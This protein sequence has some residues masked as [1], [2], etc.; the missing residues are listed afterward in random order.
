M[1][2]TKE[3]INI[4]NILEEVLRNPPSASEDI[5]S[6]K[7]K[8]LIFLKDYFEEYYKNNYSSKPKIY[9][10]IK[11]DT[12]TLNIPSL[13]NHW[14][15]IKVGNGKDEKGN[16]RIILEPFPVGTSWKTISVDLYIPYNVK[17]DIRNCIHRHA[18][19]NFYDKIMKIVKRID[20]NIKE[21]IR[22]VE[23]QPFNNYYMIGGSQSMLDFYIQNTLDYEHSR[24]FARPH[25]I[26]EEDLIRETNI[27]RHISKNGT[28]YNYSFDY[29][30]DDLL[31]HYLRTFR[32]HR[33][34]IINEYRN[35]KNYQIQGE[36]F[37]E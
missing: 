36:V 8:T 24:E 19:K 17:D 37:N 26:V 15:T 4:E 16:E 34:M 28:L 33:D 22:I 30:E 13:N 5:N 29:I 1:E 20:E 14:M 6:L 27:V 12:L 9:I 18:Y 23:N 3:L 11:D 2:K 35:N 21:D 7:Q 31:V 32:Y 25:I 10:E